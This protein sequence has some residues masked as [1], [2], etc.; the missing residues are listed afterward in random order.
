MSTEADLPGEVLLL[1]FQHLTRQPVHETYSS[2]LRGLWWFNDDWGSIKALV[3]A[4]GVCWRWRHLAG[5][6][7]LWCR[8]HAAVL[9]GPLLPAWLASA[10]V[11][12]QQRQLDRVM[13]WPAADV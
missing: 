7:S 10:S 3:A 5:D 13:R 8:M 11:V 9:G 4:G 12:S 6:D 2:T 1:V